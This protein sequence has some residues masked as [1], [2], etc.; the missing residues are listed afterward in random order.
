[1]K[2]CPRDQTPAE[3]DEWSVPFLTINNI[4]FSE[5]EKTIQYLSILLSI[6][7]NYLDKF[8]K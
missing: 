8:N 5:D 2:F 3:T 1:M 4:E 7:D 6:F